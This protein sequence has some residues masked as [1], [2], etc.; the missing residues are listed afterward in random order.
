MAGRYP[1]RER[2]IGREGEREK[3]RE[4]ERKI[5]RKKET[6]IIA[7]SNFLGLF[8]TPV[9]TLARDGTKCSRAS[10]KSET[11]NIPEHSGTSPE[12]EKIKKNFMKK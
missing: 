4:K 11:W 2:E 10:I 5:E 1:R 7:G 8:Q 9:I 3:E 6:G 12:N